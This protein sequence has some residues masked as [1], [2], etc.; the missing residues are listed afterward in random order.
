MFG[1]IG[2]GRIE[3]G[4]PICDD[5]VSCIVE[6]IR[7][8]ERDR[9]GRGADNLDSGFTFVF[10]RNFYLRRPESNPLEPVGKDRY[11]RIRLSYIGHIYAYRSRMRL[12]A[13]LSKHDASATAS[14]KVRV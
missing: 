2:S 10:R 1:V 8:P 12:S 7:R 5:C 4:D 11:L 3:V 14:K 13:T 6:D 9:Q